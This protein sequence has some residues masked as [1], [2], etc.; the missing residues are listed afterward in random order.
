LSVATTVLRSGIFIARNIAP[1]P[2]DGPDVF[3]SFLSAGNNLIGDGTGGSFVDDV[4]N[5]QVGTTAALINPRLAPLANNGGFTLTHALHA[6]SKAI[7]AG[8]SAAAP[9][10]DQR[11]VARPRDGDGNGS[12]IADIGAFER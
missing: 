4:L 2:A 9:P 8:S 3:G 7:D 12:K 11:G 6:G 10:T 1:T 5:D